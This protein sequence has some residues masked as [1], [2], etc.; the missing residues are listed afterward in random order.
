MRKLQQAFLL[1]ALFFVPA[2][3]QAADVV[4]VDAPTGVEAWL[5]EE[6]TIPMIA[7]RLSIPGG[8]VYDPEDLPGV[9]SMMSSLL[10]EGACDMD[11]AAFKEALETYAIRLGFGSGREYLSVS[12]STLTENA[13]EAFRLMALALHAPRFDDAPLERVRAQ[14]LAGLRQDEEDPGTIAGKAWSEKYFLDHPYAHDPSG[15][16]ES[17]A[18]ISR[19]DIR[20]AIRRGGKIPGGVCAFW[21]GCAAAL[22]IGIAYGIILKTSPLSEEER[23]IGQEVVS[24]I[25]KEI[26]SFNAPRCCRRE[27]HLSLLW[28]CKLS[29]KYLPIPVTTTVKVSCDQK[30]L[31][32]ECIGSR[33]LLF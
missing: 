17:V 2:L 31:N 22:G 10:D 25:L 21:G 33:C 20:E 13:D 26:A 6:H 18:A 12:M 5:S 11:D 9:A 24:A 8:S 3:A 7:F 30:H 1:A 16:F 27:S 29:E 4:V 23:G 14:T 32:R 19:D 15:T 28:G